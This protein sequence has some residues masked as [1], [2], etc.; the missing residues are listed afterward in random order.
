M[1]GF[2]RRL[3]A[4]AIL[5]IGLNATA[6][7][8]AVAAEIEAVPVRLLSPGEGTVLTAGSTAIL[9]WATVADFVQPA[10]WEEHWKE[11]EAFLS[12]DGGA[13]YPVRVTPHLDR[14]LRRIRFR[15]P[16]VP[17]ENGRLLLR[18]G[19]ERQEIAFELPER[20]T[21][22]PSPGA[23]G[24]AGAWGGLPNALDLPQTVWR[25]GESA[26]P[27]EPGV[28]VW[29]EGSR[30]GGATR[31]V[32]SGVPAHLV[33][34]GIAALEGHP[35]PAAVTAAA[36]PSGAPTADLDLLQTLRPPRAGAAASPWTVRPATTDILLLIQRQNE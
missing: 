28:L 19:D 9:E 15:V 36:P 11:W 32:V 4:A 16:F 33:D 13:T 35:A 26:R 5:A 31:E 22:A 25:R 34:G 21:I 7:V 17:T 2:P 8:A 29:V 18:V 24:E 20:F 6:A 23:L 27:G 14:D 1:N 10:P 30:Q 12:L 3:A